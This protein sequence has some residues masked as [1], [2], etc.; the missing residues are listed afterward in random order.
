MLQRMAGLQ[1]AAATRGYHYHAAIQR[2]SMRV[3][4]YNGDTD[5]SINMFLAQNWTSGMGFKVSHRLQPC[6][7]SVAAWVAREAARLHGLQPWGV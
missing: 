1:P 3:L 5:P 7:A 4:V 2:S 6:V